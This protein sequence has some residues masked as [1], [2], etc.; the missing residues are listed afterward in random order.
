MAG[1]FAAIPGVP[2]IL[3][4]CSHIGHLVSPDSVHWEYVTVT[5]C[6]EEH[7]K[8]GASVTEVGQGQ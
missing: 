8:H 1:K 5:S 3:I 6:R 4:Q 7:T 2:F